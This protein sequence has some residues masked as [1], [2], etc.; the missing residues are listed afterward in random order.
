M[1]LG[2]LSP[3]QTKILVALAGFEPA[4]TLTGGG[5]LAGFHTAH[6][7]TRDLDLFWRGH[8]TISTLV[9]AVKQRLESSGMEAT[10]LQDA[11]SFFRFTVRDALD[12]T[13][14]D[15]VADPVA[16]VTEPEIMFVEG[17]EIGVDTRHEI[18]VNKLVTVLGRSELRDLLDIQVLLETGGDLVRAVRDAPL[19]DGGFS[20]VTLAWLLRGFAIVELAATAKWDAERIQR[21]VSFRD[22]LVLRL[23]DLARP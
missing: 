13:V 9:H 5:A 18:L 22:E 1:S 17:H 20:P 15:L 23:T 4:W 6:R 3:L 10:L 2:S 21:L 12:S 14:L 8:T 16:N 7:K 11:G 19:K